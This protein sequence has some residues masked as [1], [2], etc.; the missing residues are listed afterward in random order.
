MRMPPNIVFFTWHDA[1]DWFGCYGHR[2]VRTPNVDRLAREGVRFTRNFSACAICSP[3]RAALMTGL[4]CQ[5]TGVMR[6]TNTAF[7]ARIH[8]HVTHLARRVR[9][10]GYSTALIG[11]QHE[12]A[13]EHVDEIMGFDEQIATDPWANADLLAHHASRWISQRASRPEPFYL[14]M[15]TIEA[16]LNRFYAGD[17]PR[18]DE[19]YP[20]LQD[21]TLGLEIPPYLVDNE[22]GRAT[23]ATLQG[24]LHRGDRLMGAVLDSLDRHGLAEN[25]LVVM[26]V[27]HGV[28]LSRAK[29]TAY[30]AGHKTAWIMRWPGHIPAGR[31]VG[32]LTTH[33]DVLPTL[34]ELLGW[35]H[36]PGL[37]GFSLAS[38]VRGESE[39]EARDAVYGHMVENLRMV[40]TRTHKLIRNFRPGASAQTKGDCASQLRSAPKPTRFEPAPD[41]LPNLRFPD[42][43]LYH[44]PTDPHEFQNLAADPD[45][46]ATRDGLDRK[47]WDFLLDNDDFIVHEPV[48]TPWQQSTRHALE[49]HCRRTGRTLPRACGPLA[50]PIDGA[51]NRGAVT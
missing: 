1:G 35:G 20:P 2:T 27:D 32:A 24:L 46:A 13:H 40:R 49:A 48:R 22:A 9:N 15:G 37:D 12:A 7:D 11:I 17:P 26:A 34:A 45:H 3:S 33:V 51:S 4:H 23:V 44:L 8:P 41:Q 28:G 47:L 5:R 6:L 50:D 31:E 29:T 14:Q 30:D 19:P 10:R 25:T 21:T 16:H 42:L 39:A 38:Q 43:E 18:A 36:V